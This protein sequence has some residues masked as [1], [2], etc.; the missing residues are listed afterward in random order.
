DVG[1]AGHLTAWFATPGPVPGRVGQ[2]GGGR[3][4]VAVDGNLTV[5][6]QPRHQLDGLRLIERDGGERDADV[7][8]L[9]RRDQVAGGAGPQ[10]Q[11]DHRVHVVVRG[12]Q[13]QAPA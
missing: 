2:R 1:E 4:R 12:E 7:G 13:L 3:L 10:D 9:D 5:T 8:V 6:G 11:R